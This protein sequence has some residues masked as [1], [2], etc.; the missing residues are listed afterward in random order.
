MTSRGGIEPRQ[1]FKNVISNLISRLRNVEE[2][3]K[4]FS[5]DINE[6]Y[7]ISVEETITIGELI[8]MEVHE[9]DPDNESFIYNWREKPK[10]IIFRSRSSDM[11]VIISNAVASIIKKLNII[12]DQL[13]KVPAA[14]NCHGFEELKNNLLK[15]YNHLPLIGDSREVAAKKTGNKDITGGWIYLLHKKL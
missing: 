4:T 10:H 13:D 7:K 1:L 11:N 9:L 8:F 15:T 3:S 6:I 12:G 5:Q 14:I 2:I